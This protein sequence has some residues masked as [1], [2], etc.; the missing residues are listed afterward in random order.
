M[1]KQA[2]ARPRHCKR[3]EENGVGEIDGNKTGDRTIEPEQCYRGGAQKMRKAPPGHGGDGGV[4]RPGK[5]QQQSEDC[6]NIDG[7]KK[8]GI[9]VEI[10]RGSPIIVRQSISETPSMLSRYANPRK[11]SV[12]NGGTVERQDGNGFGNLSRPKDN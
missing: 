8:Q 1:I 2:G 9:D 12:N 11:K 3:G 4:L 7:D 5:Q 10:H 6:L